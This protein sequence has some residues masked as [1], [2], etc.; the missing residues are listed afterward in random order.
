M[1]EKIIIILLFFYF[2][3]TYAQ[4]EAGIWYFGNEAGLDF[5]SGTPV[6]LTDGKLITNEG[7]ASISDKEGNLLFYTDGSTVW[8][9]NH[10]VMSNGYGLLGHPSSTQSAI[11]IPNPS[12]PFS[13]YIFT[14]DQPD[15]KNA[16]DNPVN[17]QDDEVNDG[18]NYTEINMNLNGGLGDVNPL[19]KNIHLITYNT[20]DA[21]EAAYKCSEKIT[22]V[23]H[24]DGIS[25]WVITHFINKFYAFKISKT[26]VLTNPVISK[27]STL[28]P[29]AGYLNNGIGYLKSSPNGKKLA[30]AHASSKTNNDY[31]PKGNPIRDTGKVLLYNFDN[32]SGKV[33]DEISLLSNENPYGL[34]FSSKSKKLY[35]TVNNAGT[36]G[37]II[38]SSLFQF[39]LENNNIPTSKIL[40]KKSDFNAGA[41]QLAIDEKIYRSGYK[42]TESG[43]S[44]LSVINNPEENGVACNFIENQVN[45]NGKKALLGLPP[46][47]QSLFLFNFKYE[48]TCFGD[49]T[50]FSI[51]TIETIDTVIWDFGDG[52]TSTAFD[53]YHTYV[54]PGTYTVSLTKS[55]NGDTKEPIIKDVVINEK[56]IILNTTFELIQCDSYD[57]NPSDELAFFNLENT[58]AQLTLNKAD[59]FNVYFYLNNTDAENDIYNENPLALY[60]RNTIPNQLL[61]AKVMFSD[62]E[63]YSL[64][65]VKLIAN[66][67]RPLDVTDFIGCDIGDGTA[68][69]NF[70]FKEN[71]IKSFLNLPNS[72]KIYFYDS[73]EN[74]SNDISHLG[75]DYI[76]SEKIIYFRVENNGFCYG[77]GTFNLVVNYFPPVE[78]NVSV[79]ICESNF[80]AEI[81]VGIPLDIQQNYSYNWSNGENTYQISAVNEQQISVTI[82]DKI[83]GCE[84]VKTF[85]IVKVTTPNIIDVDINLNNNTVVI[86]TENNFDNLYVIDNP[87]NNYQSENTF[88]NVTAGLHTVYVK[89]KYDCGI[90]IKD[91][92]VLGFPK[93]FTPNNDGVNDLWEIKGLNVEEFK[94]SNILIFN[95]FGK[96]LATINPDSGWDGIY[97]GEFLPSNDY[98]FSIDVTDNENITKTYKAHFSLIRK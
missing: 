7:C 20:N 85:D 22:A 3:S 34:D 82:T 81:N 60:Y 53:T 63:C 40:I 32:S 57:S 94:Y 16:D 58:I 78:L 46:F 31:G 71:E 95:R 5:N 29:I 89:N 43:H 50:H 19:K 23:Q 49:S 54:A 21:K 48:F 97:N 87:Y 73:K 26:G 86:I 4:R 70:T 74:A 67:N 30:I 84:K 27:T 24:Y 62:S 61:T 10:N 80:P 66:S 88:Y 6:A 28:I 59:D 44:Q 14:V 8:N 12:N 37:N 18:L 77:A 56:P 92:F 90:T 41:L 98:W 93:F 91:I 9:A 35:V 33:S 52:S 64:G 25:Y 76:S 75:N 42:R 47:I 79:P 96:H 83:I 17:N 39:D 38:G 36:D 68:E 45:L 11:I 51:S 55:T 15:D 13:Y 2:T 65:K 69:F 1:K 72:V